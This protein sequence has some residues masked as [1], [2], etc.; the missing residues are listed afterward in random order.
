MLGVRP[1][2]C[3]V[4]DYVGMGRKATDS[5]PAHL[6]TGV[7]TALA[8]LVF[9]LGLYAL[10]QGLLQG[11]LVFIAESVVP[12][13]LGGWALRLLVLYWVATRKGGA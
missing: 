1:L 12:L 6:R 7:A 10:A 5:K 9:G 2:Q 3:P 4:K 8:L 11:R 13:L